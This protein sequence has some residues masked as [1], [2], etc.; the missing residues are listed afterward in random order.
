M[1]FMKMIQYVEKHKEEHFNK[2]I[3][4]NER[5]LEKKS[6]KKPRKMKPAHAYSH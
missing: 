5:K 3:A 6:L 4:E 2:V 1:D